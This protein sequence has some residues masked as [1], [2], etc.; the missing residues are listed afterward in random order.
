MHAVVEYAFF[1]LVC[2]SVALTHG[3]VVDDGIY[4]CLPCDAFVLLSAD[5][6]NQS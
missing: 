4:A 1:F 3:L 6:C 5:L 2:Q